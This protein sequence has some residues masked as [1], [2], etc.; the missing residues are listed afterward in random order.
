M[1]GNPLSF[2]H[3]GGMTGAS[4]GGD[5]TE[6]VRTFGR[7]GRYVWAGRITAMMIGHYGRNPA[8][9]LDKTGIGEIWPV[10]MTI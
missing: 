3:N 4:V 6:G 10:V 2:R 9:R 8:L 7:F 5:A 1:E